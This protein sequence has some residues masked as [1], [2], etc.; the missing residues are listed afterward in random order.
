[1]H[2]VY[3]DEVLI[4]GVAGRDDVA[5]IESFVENLAVGE[6]DHAIDDDGSIWASYG[7][8]SQPSFA[9]IGDDGAVS[10]HTGPL[11]VARLSERIDEL[12]AT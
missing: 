11:G 3:G 4:V 10:T 2:Q 9:F 5:A 8:L 6:F 7:I 12:L 1:V